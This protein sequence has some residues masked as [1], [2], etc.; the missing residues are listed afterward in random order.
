M[1][2]LGLPPEQKYMSKEQ[3][4][5]ICHIGTHTAK[6]LIENKLIPVIDTHTKTS[7]YLIAVKDVEQYLRERESNPEKYGHRFRTYGEAGVYDQNAAER[8]KATAQQLWESEKDI[9]SAP[10]VSR[11]LGYARQTVYK[12]ADRYGLKCIRANGRFYVPK[13]VLIDF[14]ASQECLKIVRKSEKHFELIRA[15]MMNDVRELE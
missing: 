4:R 15:S 10:D 14:I 2:R 5:E 6:W 9:L 12:W 1:D 3:F 11:L 7:R 8:L 13:S